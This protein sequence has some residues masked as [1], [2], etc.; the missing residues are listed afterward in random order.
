[1][2]LFSGQLALTPA[3]QRDAGSDA[4]C[5]VRYHPGVVEHAR[6]QAWFEALREQVAWKSSQRP[7]YDRIVDVP[8]LVA[9]YRVCDAPDPVGAALA[10]VRGVVDR[11]FDSVGINLYRDGCDSVAPHN[12]RLHDLVAGEPIAL[13]SLGA[14]REMVIRPKRGLPGRTL[15]IALAPGSVLVMTHASQST[16][17]HGIPK[18]RY[19]VGARISLAFRVRGVAPGGV[20]AAG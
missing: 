8:R 20:P 15:R 1:M 7:M 12:D 13:L 4:E 9:T 14:E 5:G 17:D 6:A 3:G 19:G 16:H 10:A 18:T 2:D 11:P